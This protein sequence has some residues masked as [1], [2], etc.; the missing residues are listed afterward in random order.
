MSITYST[1]DITYPIAGQDNDSQGFRDN[2]SAIKTAF[3]EAD[4]A[5]TTLTAQTLQKSSVTIDP[6]TEETVVTTVANDLLGSSIINGSFNKFYGEINQDTLSS[7]VKDIDMFNGVAQEFIIST[8]NA[9][10]FTHWPADLYAVVR[11]HLVNTSETEKTI[12]S[13]TSI[14]NG[15]VIFEDSFAS[16]FIIAPGKQRVIEAWSYDGGTNVYVRDLGIYD[17]P[18]S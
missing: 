2:F 5:L 9:L 15:N 16:N 1:I 4:L 17:A 14:N 13:F 3:S 10:R 12:T 11:V 7:S 8:S 18:V 6:E